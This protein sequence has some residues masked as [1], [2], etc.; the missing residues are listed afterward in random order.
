MRVKLSYYVECH[1]HGLNKKIIYQKDYLRRTPTDTVYGTEYTYVGM[2]LRRV[3]RK[4]A[5]SNTGRRAE[6]NLARN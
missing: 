2:H 1:V 3:T 6:V 4:F 5:E